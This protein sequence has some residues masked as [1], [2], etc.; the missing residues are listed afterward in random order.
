MFMQQTVIMI[1][2]MHA[3][4]QLKLYVLNTYSY[5]HVIPK[6]RAQNSQ[7]VLPI[8]EGRKIKQRS[9]MNCLKPRPKPLHSHLSLQKPGFPLTGWALACVH[10]PES[11][12]KAARWDGQELLI[13]YCL[14]AET[15]PWLL[16]RMLP[17]VTTAIKNA[18]DAAGMMGIPLPWR[19]KPKSQDEVCRD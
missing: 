13:G 12:C 18:L 3:Y 17:L 10:V 19:G 4:L 7:N 11:P 8:E 14:Q 5:M 15:V 16:W 9:S 6:M 1:S 2:R